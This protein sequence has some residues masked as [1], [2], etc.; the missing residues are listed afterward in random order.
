MKTIIYYFTGTGNSL[1]VAKEI[2]A[3]LGDTGCVPLASLQGS[4]GPVIPQADRVGIVCPVYFAGLPSIV[5]SF[6]GELDLTSVQYVFSVVTFGGSGESSA[7]EQLDGILRG[8]S[9]RGLDAGFSVKMPGNYI[10]MYDSLSGEKRDA[11]LAA[12]RERI[13][14]IAQEIL[15]GRKQDLPHSFLQ[16]IIHSLLYSRFAAGVHGKDRQFTVSDAC[17]SC[18]ICAAVCPVHNIDL[19]EGKPAWKHRCELCCACIHL[20]PAE[21]IQAGRSTGKRQRYRNPAVSI[22]EL[23]GQ[24]GPGHR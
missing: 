19:V 24:T 3:V 11:V 21:A 4:K 5:A 20:C 1:A 15:Q 17:T 8:R 23:K 2:A 6:A 22:D 10:L 14:R 13:A 12:A 16:N 7:L 9:G 18:G